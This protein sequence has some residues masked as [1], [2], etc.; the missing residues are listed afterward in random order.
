M[1]EHTRAGFRPSAL[2]I[3]R[4]LLAA[5]CVLTTASLTW[6]QSRAAYLDQPAQVI[7][8]DDYRSSRSYPLLIFLP[9]TTG[10][11]SEFFERH[12]G[13][14]PMNDVIVLLPAG[15]PDREDYLPD[16]MSYIGWYEQMLLPQIERTVS[17]YNVD[18]D[19]MAIGGFSLGGDL[20]WALMLRNP[21]LF[22]GAVMAGT[23]TSYPASAD[24]LSRL[25]DRAVRAAFYI[26]A[27]ES[28]ARRDGIERAYAA[29]RDAGIQASFEVVSGGHVSGPAEEFAQS[30]LRSVGIADR[31]GSGQTATA[32]VETVEGRQAERLSTRVGPAGSNADPI[33][34]RV[35]NMS[36]R[37]V[38]YLALEGRG[39]ADD[40]TIFDVDS[41]ASPLPPGARDYID[42]HRGAVLVFRLEGSSQNERTPPLR[43]NVR[44]AIEEDG[45]LR[46]TFSDWGY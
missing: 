18:R 17:E 43:D 3:R 44:I 10:T 21:M 2:H 36:S 8:P 20:A 12:R 14:L 31:S 15:R 11:A 30:M 37:A 23:R 28:P 39:S 41:V 9:F 4:V 6:G 16:F 27:G 42:T 5:V 13:Y 7:V 19:R 46:G 38:V 24:V 32:L 45:T 1:I 29:V 25:R 33:T 26:G 34:I 35:E 40:V 22:T